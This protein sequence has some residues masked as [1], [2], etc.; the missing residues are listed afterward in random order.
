MNSSPQLYP[1]IL[2]DYRWNPRGLVV[3]RD[4]QHNTGSQLLFSYCSNM[5]IIFTPLRIEN[6]Q[7]NRSILTHYYPFSSGKWAF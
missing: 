6:A 5:N 1:V 3:C 4:D 7:S 2:S